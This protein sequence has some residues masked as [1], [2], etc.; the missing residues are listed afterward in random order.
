M[1]E[2][3]EGVSR[4][5]NWFSYFV[6][7]AKIKQ[8]MEDSVLYTFLGRRRAGKSIN[9]LAMACRI[10]PDITVENICFG[11]KELTAALREKSNTAIIWEEAGAAGGYNRAWYSPANMLVNKTLQVYG[12]KRIAIL[13][14][15]QHLNILDLQVRVQIDC[16]FKCFSDHEKVGEGEFMKHTYFEPWRVH[17]DFMTD[18]AIMKYKIN[19]NGVFQPIGVVPMPQ[20]DE[21]FKICGVKKSLYNDYRKK[22]TEFF[23]HL[24]EEEEQA[25][26]LDRK[27][28]GKLERMSAGCVALIK[29]LNDEK[30]MKQ[31]EIAKVIGCN[32]NT[33]SGWKNCPLDEL[34]INQ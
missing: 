1:S 23:E 19:R 32:Q 16:I 29:Y 7:Q 22:K 9:T 31:G 30:K 34:T 3:G 25:S 2:E 28:I 21:L 17:T 27:K 18:P 24:G 15:L 5:F 10:D 12:E 33:V 8:Q 4:K 14:N 26:K 6:N 20:V 11:A 13:A